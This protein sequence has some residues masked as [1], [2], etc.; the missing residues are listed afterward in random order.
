MQGTSMS[1]INQMKVSVSGALN[2]QKPQASFELYSTEGLLILFI[3]RI[4]FELFL[5]LIQ[6]IYLNCFYDK[7]LLF[8]VSLI[9]NLSFNKSL[10]NL[11]EY[12]M[13]F[14][15]DLA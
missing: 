8:S 3:A 15:H 11:F 6:D 1:I 14:L 2:S 9:L 4:Q 5:I 12:D 7:Y 13:N 10:A